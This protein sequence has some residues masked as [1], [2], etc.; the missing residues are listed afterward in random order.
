MYHTKTLSNCCFFSQGPK[1]GLLIIFCLL[2]FYT[3]LGSNNFNNSSRNKSALNSI[4]RT[5]SILESKELSKKQL[6]ELFSMVEDYK[7]KA[8][9]LVSRVART[10]LKWSKKHQN[11]LIRA[12]SLFWS[13]WIQ[14]Q[15]IN[16]G[17]DIADVRVSAEISHRLIERENNPFW[18]ARVQDLLATIYAYQTKYDTA[19]AILNKAKQ[20]IPQ[21]KN[22]WRDS[23][24]ILAETY[25]TESI[26]LAEQSSSNDLKVIDVLMKSADLF[27]DLKLPNERARAYNN[28]AAY[29]QILGLQANERKA[30]LNAYKLKDQI[31]KQELSTTLYRLGRVY[32][33]ENDSTLLTKGIDY[34]KRSIQASKLNACRSCKFLAR[35][36]YKMNRGY[37]DS[38]YVYLEKAINF[39]V[40][41][42]NINCL[43]DGLLKNIYAI[44]SGDEDKFYELLIAYLEA[45][46]ILY[47]SGKESLF[48]ASERIAN[49]DLQSLD[50][51]N[52]LRQR[53]IIFSILAFV[54]LMVITGTIYHY[55]QQ[56]KS[57]HRELDAKSAAARA[58]IN[59]HFIANALNAIAGLIERG[60]Y[61]E[62]S[63][64]LTRFARLSRVILNNARQ[65]IGLLKKEFTLLEDY[66][67][68][69][70]LRFS[71]HLN[72][73]IQIDKNLS[74]NHFSFPSMIIQPIVE[75]AI[76]HG[77]SNK[78][79]SGNI[80]IQFWLKEDKR[81]ECIVQDDGIGRV[82]ARK[83]KQE[84][85]VNEESMGQE[86][87]EDR[88]KTLRRQ[89]YTANM[90]IMDLYDELQNPCGTRV[91][92]ELPILE[93]TNT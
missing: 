15:Q 30:A 46:K 67:A 2:F 8:P 35:G 23:I 16:R 86:I 73:D 33:R 26:I 70:K 74:H 39:A 59:P 45:D 5:I 3:E 51:A 37:Q 38:A 72:Y 69:E 6:H 12:K 1:N 89:G 85:N 52:K 22:N 40:K 93:K 27:K 36:Y 48:A 58:H 42:N 21:I 88:L 82:A 18:L 92:L 90:H 83:L 31:E 77:I 57:L 75:N 11:G 55:R 61:R 17:E 62:A 24:F 84:S 41:H 71:D 60:K 87:I 25:N 4:D 68:L 20:N 66:L 44:C 29:Y 79:N 56:I 78:S 53:K 28:M 13:G 63:K 76:I 49:Y 54:G 34:L 91:E 64:Y 43:H 50:E 65:P 32:L 80:Q 9:N 47:K 7:Y 19:S 10:G 14:M 81:L